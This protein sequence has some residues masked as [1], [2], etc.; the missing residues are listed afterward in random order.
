MTRTAYDAVVLAGGAARRLGGVDKP[1]LV[2]GERSLLER[3]LAAVGDA[4]RVVVVGPP[5]PLDPAV[6]Q[7]REDPPGGGPAAAL[8]AG[9]AQVHSPWVA[10]LAADLP[11]VSAAVVS[12]LREAAE[13]HEGAVLVDDDGRDQLLTGVWSSAPLH[14]ATRRRD[15]AGLPLRALLP[16][17]DVARVPA[18]RLGLLDWADC[19]TP[20]DLIRARK[21]KA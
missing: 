14:A 11:H 4:A 15:L 13:G 9:L 8:A 2:V 21:A 18:S 7:V 6:V 5:R 10:L 1:A 19:D 20:D 12:A 17:L 3:A 16:G